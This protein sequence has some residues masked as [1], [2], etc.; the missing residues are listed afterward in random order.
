MSDPVRWLDVPGMLRTDPP[1]VDWIIEGVVARGTLT[2]LAGR[3]KQGKS[4]MTL[5]LAARVATGGGM[6]A[7]VRCNAGTVA[8]LDA[9]NGEQLIHRRM[10]LLGLTAGATD[11]LHAAE[12]RGLD[13]ARGLTHLDQALNRLKPDL[14]ILDSW[15]S[16]W[17]GDENDAGQVAGVLDPLRN[18]IRRHNTAAVLIHHMSKSGGYRGSTATGAS[19]ENVLELSRADDDPNPR[20]RRLRNAACRYEEEAPERWFTIENDR[21]VLLLGECEAFVANR[22]GGGDA[23]RHDL[24]DALTDEPQPQGALARKVGRDKNDGTVRRK[25]QDLAKQG[26][27]ERTDDGW[28]RVPGA[29][30]GCR[31]TLAPPLIHGPA[32]EEM[33]AATTN[34]RA[35]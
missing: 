33:P 4:L 24:L 5:A 8:V 17:N 22:S 20:R 1:P 26:A 7:G 6:L 16:L 2:L 23:I 10:R 32:D 30:G 3:E 15:R 27:A 18:L 21:G 9:E 25:L 34:G 19:V 14:L 35:V 11:A 13:L 29:T 12:V 31:G 28:R